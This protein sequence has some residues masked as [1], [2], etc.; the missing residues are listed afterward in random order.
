MQCQVVFALHLH[1]LYCVYS[2][3]A[4]AVA[5]DTTNTTTTTPS[6]LNQQ[7]EVSLSSKTALCPLMIPNY[8]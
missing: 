3:P 1:A 8:L 5:N 2:S 4:T 7:K 6:P